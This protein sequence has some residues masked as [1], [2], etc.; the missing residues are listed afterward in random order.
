MAKKKARYRPK[1]AS[2]DDIANEVAKVYREVRNGIIPAKDSGKICYILQQLFS[3]RKDIKT[4]QTME[5]L[6]A[7]INALTEGRYVGTEAEIDEVR[8]S[9]RG[10]CGEV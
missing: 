5:E 6:E 1:L 10:S 3:M 7:K 4:A 9:L 2:L 8:D